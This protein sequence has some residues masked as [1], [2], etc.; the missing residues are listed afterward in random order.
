AA[1]RW[2]FRAAVTDPI[3][4]NRREGSK[5]TLIYGAGDIGHQ[6]VS[7]VDT[8]DE[9]PYTIAGFIDESPAKRY[10]RI[11]GHRVLGRG[12]DLP[13]LAQQRGVVV[14]ILAIRS[15]EPAFIQELADRLEPV[16]ITLVVV[17]PVREMIDGQVQLGQLREFNVADL[18]GRR[19]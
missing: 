7:L 8:A 17:P 16:G 6:V 9:P 10:L 13:E 3:L 14:I 18:L 15:A 12:V 5:R 11:R 2:V 1:G 4:R 19:P